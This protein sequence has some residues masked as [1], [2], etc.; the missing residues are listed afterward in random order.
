MSFRRNVT[1]NDNKCSYFSTQYFRR[2]E[3]NFVTANEIDPMALIM[4]SG[5]GRARAVA[6]D[7]NANSGGSGGGGGGGSSQS[8]KKMKKKD[9]SKD[10]QKDAASSLIV[11][12]LKRLLPVGLNLFAGREQELVQHCKD[13]YLQVSFITFIP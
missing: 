4:P 10:K 8:K 9:K 12:A 13:R 3:T 7:P 1:C 2:E 11:A 5:I 6:S